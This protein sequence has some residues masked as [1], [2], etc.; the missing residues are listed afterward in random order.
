MLG[1][2]GSYSFKSQR[3]PNPCNPNRGTSVYP[4]RDLA[5]TVN[6]DIVERFKSPITFKPIIN[7]DRVSVYVIANEIPEAL[8]YQQFTFSTRNGNHHIRTPETCL[9]YT[10]PSPRDQRGSRMPSSA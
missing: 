7:G 5:I 3:Y 2:V 8:T 1:L 4:S 10:S 6:S 9:L